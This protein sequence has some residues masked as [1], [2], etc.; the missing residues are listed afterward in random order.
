MDIREAI[1]EV[2]EGRDLAFGAAADVMR[3]IMGGEASPAQFGAF[4]TGL[5]M[6]GETAEEIAGMARSMRDVSLHVDF[7]GPTV[8]T[9]GTGGDG[10]KTFN[11]STAAAFVVAGTGAVVAKHGNRA[12]SSSSGSA[13]ALE[14]LN[15]NID[16]GP[17]DVQKCLE[18]VGIGFM[19]A[20]AFHPA[21]KF[22]GPLRPQIGIRTIFNL[23]GPLTNP[24][25]ADHQVIGMGD[26]GGAEKV[27][28][29]LQILGTSGALVVYSEDGMDEISP[30]GK[31]HMYQVL[32]GQVSERTVDASDFGLTER[33]R[34]D[35]TANTVEESIGLIQGVLEGR[36]SGGVEQAARTVVVMNAAALLAVGRAKTLEQAALLAADSID[37]GKALDKLETLAAMSQMLALK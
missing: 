15:V 19:F 2:V 24:A 27:A 25:G 5:R 26:P 33:K 35:L 31:S 8:D 22:A 34:S 3:Q 17:I 1:T 32:D 13:D 23:L 12:M 11:I 14:A 36:N 29:A 20:Q 16:L 7:D 18:Q 21:M 6:K 37:S 4:V 28:R 9:C 30:E 10:Q